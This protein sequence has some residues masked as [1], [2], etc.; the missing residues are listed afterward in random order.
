MYRVSRLLELCEKVGYRV[1]VDR[2][3]L[4]TNMEFLVESILAQKEIPSCSVTIVDLDPCQGVE[5]GLF[6]NGLFSEK[7]IRSIS[8]NDTDPADACDQTRGRNIAR[9][10]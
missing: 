3:A 6:E 2:T 5:N 4:G 1:D 9:F 7:L 8:E 10:E